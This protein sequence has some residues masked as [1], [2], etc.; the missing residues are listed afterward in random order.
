MGLAAV[1]LGVVTGAML[2][3][4]EVCVTGPLMMFLR[5]P[6]RR[7]KGDPDARHAF[8]PFPLPTRPP[9]AIRQHTGASAAYAPARDNDPASHGRPGTQC[10]RPTRVAAMTLMMV[11]VRVGCWELGRADA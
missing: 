10:R 7:E 2:R 9:E 5:C 6:Q 8:R 3:L 4:S 1:A 11:G